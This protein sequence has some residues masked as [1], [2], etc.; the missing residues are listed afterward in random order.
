[1]HIDTSSNIHII[2]YRKIWNKSYLNPLSIWG[3][4]GYLRWTGIV[5][6]Y[7]GKTTRSLLRLPIFIV[8]LKSPKL[9]IL[10]D[11]SGK[12]SQILG[13]KNETFSVSWYT[14]FT[15]GMVNWELCLR[16]YWRSFFFS[17][18]SVIIGGDRHLLAI[19]ISMT[20]SWIFLL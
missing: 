17:N 5:D 1:M 6:I 18:Y 13:P 20:R 14:E 7:A 8:A 9:S 15:V 11:L 4:S 2:F 10:F 19:Y 16:L 3:N 12:M